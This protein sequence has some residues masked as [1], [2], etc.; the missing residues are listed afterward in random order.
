RELQFHLEM[1]ALETGDADAAR[2]A[3]GSP[4]AWREQGRDVWGWRWL[5]ETAR[6]IHFALR[7]IRGS[8]GFAAAAILTLALGIGANC[9]MFSV[10]DATLFRP[11]PFREPER[12]VS[13]W[14]SARGGVG[15]ASNPAFQKWRA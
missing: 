2:R 13:V 11:L 1:K 8:P 5:D 15:M 10:V 3:L 14:G 4:L 7:G 9:L 6:D 12:L